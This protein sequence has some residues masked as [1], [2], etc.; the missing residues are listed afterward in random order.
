MFSSS[1][2]MFSQVVTMNGIKRKILANE[3]GEKINGILTF[4]GKNT[5]RFV[6]AIKN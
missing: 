1:T 2:Y 3:T 4:S 6:L 5:Q